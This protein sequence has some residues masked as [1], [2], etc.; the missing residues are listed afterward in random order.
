MLVPTHLPPSPPRPVPCTTAPSGPH[1]PPLAPGRAW[2]P[3]DP[4]ARTVHTAHR[5][6]CRE[7]RGEAL[8]RVT[9]QSKRPLSDDDSDDDIVDLTAD[10]PPCRPVR[11]PPTADKKAKL[12]GA[13]AAVPVA[14]PAAGSRGPAKAPKHEPNVGGAH[15]RPAHAHGRTAPRRAR[16]R[17]SSILFFSA[18]MVARVRARARGTHM[19]VTVGS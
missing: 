5:L 7:G 8:T 1:P 15:R 11:A 10:A 2:D 18:P 9:A 19:L 14:V 16:Q 13:G 12:E 6:S 17:R 3:A 4:G